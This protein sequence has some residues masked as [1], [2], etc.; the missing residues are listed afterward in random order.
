M[1]RWNSVFAPWPRRVPPGVALIGACVV[2][3]AAALVTVLSIDGGPRPLALTATVT[4]CNLKVRGAAQVSYTL[5]NGDRTT[6][7]Y[8]VHVSVLHGGNILGSGTSLLNHVPAG[9]SSNAQA[10]V[11]VVT[12]G[13][14][15]TCAVH[16]EVFD[17][18][19]GHHIA[20]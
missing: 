16:A 20:D 11:P 6:H 3:L 8:L 10:L 1:Q 19:T 14:G 4:T 7:G 12:A 9:E 13:P 17:A 5:T 15:A 2:L 18:D